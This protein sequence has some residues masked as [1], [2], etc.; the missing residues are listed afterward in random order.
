[1]STKQEFIENA[2]KGKILC[3]KCSKCGQI[4]LSTIYFCN[5]C[6]SK[7]FEDHI[8]E[9]QGTVSTYTIITVPPDG[10][11]EYTPYAWVVLKLND[12]DLRISGF[13]SGIASTN[14]LPVGTNAKVI[15]FDNRGVLLEK[16]PNTVN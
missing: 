2:K 10:F 6:S 3:N 5:K 7:S 13:M 15:G 4:H 11:E 16:Q 14:D 8:L 12:T 1:M 9:G